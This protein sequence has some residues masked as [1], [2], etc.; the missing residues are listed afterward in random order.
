MFVTEVWTVYSIIS[1]TNSS[2]I[3]TTCS[4]TCSTTFPT[5]ASASIAEN[6]W[7]ELFLTRDPAR[8][9]KGTHRMTQRERVFYRLWYIFGDLYLVVPLSADW[10]LVFDLD[11]LWYYKW[12]VF[13]INFSITAN[14]TSTIYPAIPLNDLSYSRHWQYLTQSLSD[15]L[16][17]QD[18]KWNS[19][20][21]TLRKYV[22][23][24]AESFVSYLVESVLVA[25]ILVFGQTDIYNYSLSRS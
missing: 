5:I 19:W 9:S 25:Q 22:V 16:P 8:T 1:A 12:T 2:T 13:N 21:E 11:F 20:H 14:T 18:V 4:T 15:Q 24:K 23:L 10:L 3:S 17:G 6:V 7:N